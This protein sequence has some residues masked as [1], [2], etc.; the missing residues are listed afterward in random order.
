MSGAEIIGVVSAIIA[1]LDAAVK[2]YDTVSD[3]S[4]LPLAFRDVARRLPLVTETM[5]TVRQHLDSCNPDESVYKAVEPI[6]DSCKD[7]ASRLERIFREVIPQE[8]ASRMQRYKLAFRTLGKGSLVESL[9]KG[10]LDDVQLLAG[11]HIMKLG[12]EADLRRLAEASDE[13][14]TLPPSLPS[15]T[16]HGSINNHGSGF[17]NI[18]TGSG[19]QI[20]NNGAGQQFI[21]GS[22]A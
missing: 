8:S 11:N 16:W 4:G 1:I 13:V 5:Q 18:N 15:N 20:N 14:S 2:V 3:A 12:T 19:R 6:A 22:F 21:G 17:Q 10:I 9:M 7:K